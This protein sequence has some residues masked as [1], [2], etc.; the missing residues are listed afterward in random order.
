MEII[1]NIISGVLF[2]GGILFVFYKLVR[3]NMP[4]VLLVGIDIFGAL[5]VGPAV[6]I[7]MTM[8]P[9][10]PV[11]LGKIMMYTCGAG[12]A[13]ALACLLAA[14]VCRYVLRNDRATSIALKIPIF[15][16]GLW[17]GTLFCG[18]LFF[19]AF[20]TISTI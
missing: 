1:L 8:G 15:Y 14:F 11:F 2:V 5:I 12:I 20:L 6:M 10:E 7:G 18:G 17:I 16:A 4:H 13:L 3:G 9:I 19:T